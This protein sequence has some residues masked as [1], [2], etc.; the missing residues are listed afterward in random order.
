MGQFY[1]KAVKRKLF[2]CEAYYFSSVTYPKLWRYKET[3][4]IVA[5]P[6]EEEGNPNPATLV[7]DKE[8]NE[9]VDAVLYHHLKRERPHLDDRMVLA[10]CSW[11]DGVAVPRNGCIRG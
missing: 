1:V 7:E 10:G 2:K 11:Q 6:R 4:Q 3:P 5:V 9:R 8:E